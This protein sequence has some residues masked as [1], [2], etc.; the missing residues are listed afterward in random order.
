M[1]HQV[2]DSVFLKIVSDF[3]SRKSDR[4]FNVCNDYLWLFL[5]QPLSAIPAFFSD[6]LRCLAST[7]RVLCLF[8]GGL[9]PTNCGFEGGL[10]GI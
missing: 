5:L 9:T 3:Y 8:L 7:Q 4:Y 2:E 6:T 10:V 1:Q